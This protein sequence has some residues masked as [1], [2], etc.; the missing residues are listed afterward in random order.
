VRIN[1]E[2]LLRIAQD[3]VSQR[4]RA[5]R[6]IQSVYLCG[7]L[8]G[9]DY[10][11]GGTA[12]IDLVF[13][14]LD[15]PVVERE[16]VRLTEDVHLDI[17]HHFE[18]DYRQARALRLHPWL[19]PT[20]AGCKILFDPQHYMDFT[21]ASVRGQFYHS[22][23]ILGRARPQAQHARQ[24]WLAYSQEIPDV[25]PKELAL[26]LRAVDHA[27]NAIASL[28]GE[29]LTERRFLLNFPARA[30]A[31]GQPGLYPGLLG[32]LGAPQVSAD[33]LNEW[34]PLWQAALEEIPAEE[35]PARL[36]PARYTYYRRSF[37][38]ILKKEQPMAVLWPLLRT[39]TDTARLLP[40]D[41]DGLESWKQACRQ[42]GLAGPAFAGR[43]AALD[44]YLDLV[45]ETLE[46]WALRNGVA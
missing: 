25:G 18:R 33:V 30:E 23:T 24:I 10:L 26:Y 1:R 35:A 16:V 29:P 2:T 42:L 32:L 34:L 36:R 5:D 41:A 40:S 38:S 3:T 13:I 46:Q 6:G 15:R 22:E 12:D 11:L 14:H 21:Q 20:I 7:A 28:S 31:V 27:V 17:A 44:A 43:V 39:W 8:L 45:E 19:G 4:A 9:E 37:E